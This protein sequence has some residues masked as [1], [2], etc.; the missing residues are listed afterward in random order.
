[1]L[2]NASPLH[3]QGQHASSMRAAAAPVAPGSLRRPT[4]RSISSA[5]GTCASHRS[6]IAGVSSSKPADQGAG[7]PGHAEWG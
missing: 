6:I 4:T 2:C 1:M 7:R 3:N 5:S